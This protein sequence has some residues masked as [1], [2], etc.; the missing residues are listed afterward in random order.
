MWPELIAELADGAA[1]RLNPEQGWTCRALAGPSQEEVVKSVHRQRHP[2]V[3]WPIAFVHC[4]RAHS[5]PP[6]GPDASH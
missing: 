5:T 1:H 2:P 3:N 6:R 4:S